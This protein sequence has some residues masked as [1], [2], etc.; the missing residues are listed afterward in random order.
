MFQLFLI[1]V[2]S[3]GC[4]IENEAAPGNIDNDDDGQLGE[5]LDGDADT[6]TDT[7]TDTAPEPGA[8]EK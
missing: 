5:D 3:L 1:L 2:L 4:S 7:A 8:Q 6:D